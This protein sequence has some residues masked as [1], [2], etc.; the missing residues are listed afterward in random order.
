MEIYFSGGVENLEWSNV[1]R[2]I[3]I[4]I[5]EYQNYEY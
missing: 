2:P 5:S 1:E 4:V 3:S